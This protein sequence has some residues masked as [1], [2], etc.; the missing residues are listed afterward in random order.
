MARQLHSPRLMARVLLQ[1]A[2]QK[3]SAERALL[4]S[5]VALD[6]N[7]SELGAQAADYA[8]KLNP[9]SPDPYVL[10]ARSALL[11]A[12]MGRAFHYAR[13]AY[14]K[15]GSPVIP[16]IF[17][18]QVDPWLD[19]A[20][21]RK[22]A[23][24]YPR[25]GR[26]Q[27]IYARA[28]LEVGDDA[29]ALATARKGLAV[30]PEAQRPAG[31]IEAQ[32][33]WN[34]G[35]KESALLLAE[36]LL[37]GTPNDLG[38]RNFYAGLLARDSRFKQAREALSNG[39]ALAPGDAHIALV[40]ALIDTIEGQTEA[41]Q[42]RL[43]RVLE[44]GGNMA[45][46]YN[47]LGDI[48]AGKGRWGEAFGWYQRVREGGF[49]GI[50]QRAAVYALAHWRGSKAARSYLRGLEKAL[51][52]YA[53]TWAGVEASLDERAGHLTAAYE[54]LGRAVRRYPMV[55]P[56]RYQRAVLADRLHQGRSALEMLHRLVMQEP[57]NPV[58]MNA[59][60]YTLAEHTR[61]LRSAQTYI[62]RALAIDPGNGAYLDSM[63]WVLYRMGRPAKALPYLRRAWAKTGA[64]DVAA[65]LARVY[66]A[67]GKTL[68]AQRVVHYALEKSPK[69]S[70]LL[71]L[72][73][74]IPR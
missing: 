61:H 69:N 24:K 34:M 7:D 73:E 38:L 35:R 64:A 58:Y 17:R 63:G 1:Q 56:L 37:A 30:L 11:E 23:K 71:K 57:G 65:H 26:L 10:L 32:A 43:T 12:Q 16:L 15:G 44:A 19:Y 52:G 74:R 39:R 41:A 45:G 46:A 60:G 29:A 20:L 50:A 6:G 28:A 48:A 14:R 33:L 66:L 4:A 27:L 5:L 8:R 31:M 22:V 18:G 68:K 21:A 62:V 59:Y 9:A 3:K 2:R 51:P 53:P 36:K 72:L 70:R 55:R 25:D 54:L 13:L 49:A 42:D 47:L 40:R 67:L